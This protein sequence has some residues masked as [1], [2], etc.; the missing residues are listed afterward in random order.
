MDIFYDLY[1]VLRFQMK[2]SWKLYT[3]H[4][5]LNSSPIPQDFTDE[6]GDDI[7]SLFFILN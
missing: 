6:I 2:E 3:C 4:S 7:K 1:Y 5:E